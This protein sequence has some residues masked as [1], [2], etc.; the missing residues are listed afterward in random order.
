MREIKFRQPIYGK[1][2]SFDRWHYWGFIAQCGCLIFIGPE[3][4]LSTVDGAYKTSQQ[5][6]GR[7]DKNKVGVYEQDIIRNELG[8]RGLGT[9]IWQDEFARFAVEVKE[10][11]IGDYYGT[12]YD[13]IYPHQEV[14]GNVCE[15]PE[16]QRASTEEAD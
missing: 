3:T 11:P 15:N 7:L 10:Q 8:W 16:L 13:D 14:V 9:I 4:H 5:L 6:T 12:F 1:D 2:G